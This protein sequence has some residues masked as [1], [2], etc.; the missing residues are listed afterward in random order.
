IFSV[1]IPSL[2]LGVPS[3]LIPKLLLT[4]IL[5]FA[6]V[7]AF[8]SMYLLFSKTNYNRRHIRLFLVCSIPSLFLQLNPWMAL[9]ITHHAWFVLSIGAMVLVISLFIRFLR[10]E[11]NNDL[12]TLLK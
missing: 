1:V 7:V 2:I 9:Q 6:G 12:S 4:F 8:F 5:F 10:K 11:D 3:E